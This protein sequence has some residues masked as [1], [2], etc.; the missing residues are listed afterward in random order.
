MA[1]VIIGGQMLSLILA[2]LVTPVFYTLLDQLAG[3]W[4][5]ARRFVGRG[6]HK[7]TAVVDTDPSTNGATLHQPVVTAATVGE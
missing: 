7:G 1:K 4:R 3:G 6:P 2:L 5:R